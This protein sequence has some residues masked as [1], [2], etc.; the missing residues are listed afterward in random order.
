[1]VEHREVGDEEHHQLGQVQVVDRVVG[2]GFEPPDRV[3]G[4][5]SD[6]APDERRQRCVTRTPQ[7]SDGA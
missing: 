5:E 2:Q 6:H 4:D 1:M 3:V 7:R